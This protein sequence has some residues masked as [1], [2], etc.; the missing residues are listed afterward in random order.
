MFDEPVIQ[1]DFTVDDF[2]DIEYMN[3]HF[4]ISH[5]VTKFNHEFERCNTIVDFSENNSDSDNTELLYS[6]TDNN[7]IEFENIYNANF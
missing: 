5:D 7:Y 4:D 1:F 3:S 2:I 6:Y